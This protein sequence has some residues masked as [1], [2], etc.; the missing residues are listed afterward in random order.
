MLCLLLLSLVSSPLDPLSLSP[1]SSH[2]F[3][4]CLTFYPSFVE[5]YCQFTLLKQNPIHYFN[6]KP[7]RIKL[8]L[9]KQLSEVFSMEFICVLFN[10]DGL[11]TRKHFETLNEWNDIILWRRSWILN[12]CHS[13]GLDVYI[14]KKTSCCRWEKKIHNFKTIFHKTFEVHFW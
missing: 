8:T 1:R 11:P 7:Y 4:R 6:V 5:E 2:L 12:H 14:N 9:W 10:W 3:T 13:V